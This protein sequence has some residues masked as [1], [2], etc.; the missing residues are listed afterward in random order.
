MIAAFYT[1][2]DTLYNGG[3]G[4]LMSCDVLITSEAGGSK[5][6]VADSQRLCLD[7]NICYILLAKLCWQVM[8]PA[9][10]VI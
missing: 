3:R 10:K 6:I 4:G 7:L 9:N 1:T 2:C 8:S 5:Y